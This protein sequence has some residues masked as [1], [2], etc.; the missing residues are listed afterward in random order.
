MC[1]IVGYIGNRA[2][3][4]L[5]L[6]ALKRMEYRGY[7]SAGIATLSKKFYLKKDKGK[8]AEIDGK[9]DMADLPGFVGIGHTRWATHGKPSQANAHP[10]IDSSGRVAVVHNGII[11]NY[12]ELRQFLKKR[13]HRFVSETDTEVVPNLIAHFLNKGKNLEQSVR[14]ASRRLQGSFAL[15]IASVDEPNK[16]IA[17][18]KE[19]PLVIGLGKGEMFLASDIP[20][21]LKHTKRFILME[22]G[23]MAVLT[24]KQVVIKNLRSGAVIK[25]R[26]MEVTWTA[27]M[28]EKMG[29]PHFTL[30]E[31]FQ[32]PDA[33]RDT[34]RAGPA[35]MKNLA[36][37]LMGAGRV[38]FVACGT[39]Y[40]AA[41][42]GKYAL[43]KLADMSVEAV[44]SSEFQ[45]SCR[46][47]GKTVVFAITQSG[48]TADTL[49]A[50]RAAKARGA[51]V[52]CLT[53]VVGSSITRESDVVCHTCAG[54]EVSVVAT[55]TFAAQVAY[56]LLFAIHLAGARGL[57]KAKV[58]KLLAELEKIPNT[59][60]A[61]LAGTTPQIKKLAKRY[62]G[63]KHIYLIGRG[64]GYPMVMEGALK[65]KEITY[66][67]SEGMPAGELKH[68]TLALIEK[69]T[70]VIAIVPPGEGRAK[71][72]G[73]IEEIKARGATLI[74]VAEDG[75]GVKEHADEFIRIPPTEELFSP[76]L[77]I[78][79]LQL[80]AYYITVELGQDPDRPRSLAKSVTVE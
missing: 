2:A 20:A 68:G 1:G 43:A 3:A 60:R 17:A 4:P 74:V 41:L 19:S 63:A 25:K 22:N 77:Y 44:I 31:I 52:A 18:R 5:L 79:P 48:E 78:I 54:P 42:V 6:D 62:R 23:E 71:I 59:A 57:P 61:V 7:D 45:E 49:R 36:K 73:N 27:D 16:L 51:K 38:Y 12:V 72:V 29:Y 30:K 56:L 21:M 35:E 40:H 39:S 55:K 37:L 11:E 64:I 15:A 50:V 14:E 53:N 9:L 28:A 46:V 10:H 47:D 13:G 24:P 58:N 76:L 8:I 32:Q 69:G 70:P 26:P 80:L 67:H 66:I 65:L 34:L 33:I 75:D